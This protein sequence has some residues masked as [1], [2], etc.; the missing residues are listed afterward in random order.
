MA[1]F[2]LY[3]LSLQEQNELLDRLFVAITS[4]RSFEEVKNFF[5]DLLNPQ[6]AAMLARRLKIAEMLLDGETYDG[7]S[8]KLKVSH[9]TVAKIHHW[10][11]SE[12]GGYKVAVKNLSRL[13]ERKSIKGIKAKKALGPGWERI[14][15]IY[16]AFD[17]ES[18]KDTVDIVKDYVRQR[19]RKKSLK[20]K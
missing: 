18:V 1:R 5:K 10:V 14:K 19:K 20:V 16:P 3:K 9:A 6:E 2:N 11:N 15:K 17:L 8:R 7:I 13:D 12:R 4:L